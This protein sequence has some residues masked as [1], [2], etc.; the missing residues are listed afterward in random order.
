MP[1]SAINADFI[2]YDNTEKTRRSIERAITDEMDKFSLNH[3]PE[4]DFR[5]EDNTPDSMQRNKFFEDSPDAKDLD[6]HFRDFSMAGPGDGA[7]EL[8][9]S[10]ER[11]RGVP[12]ELGTPGIK[13]SDFGVRG[14]F[15]AS[16]SKP[17]YVSDRH[18]NMQSPSNA[19]SR[20]DFGGLATNIKRSWSPIENTRDLSFEWDKKKQSASSEIKRTTSAGTNEGYTGRSRLMDALEKVVGEES[21]DQ[22]RPRSAMDSR[23]A[24]AK[25]PVPGQYR[26]STYDDAATPRAK[27]ASRYTSVKQTSSPVPKGFK[28]QTSFMQ[29]IGLDQKSRAEKSFHPTQQYTA[30]FRIPDMTNI[31][32][33]MSEGPKPSP[34]AR[35]DGAKHV[36]INSVPVSDDDEKILTAL[37]TLQDKI[38]W[39]ENQNAN[40]GQRVVSL[41]EELR[42][43]RGLYYAEQKRA[44]AAEE[45]SRLRLQRTDSGVHSDTDHAEILARERD[46][47]RRVESNVRG[48]E[49]KIASL[50]RQLD[51]DRVLAKNLEE[52][53]D[54]AVRALAGA[55]DDAEKLKV[56]NERL[57]AE[58]DKLRRSVKESQERSAKDRIH[59]R[60][61]RERKVKPQARQVQIE[62]VEDDDD[63]ESFVDEGVERSGQNS[64]SFV[65]AVEVESIRKEME[66]ERRKKAPAFQRRSVSAPVP[67]KITVSKAVGT[68]PVKK[69]RSVSVQVQKAPK[70]TKK[71]V[72][73]DGKRVR[74]VIRQIVVEE[75]DSEMEETEETEE[76][77][78][79]EIEYVSEEEVEVL[80]RST[81]IGE[82][83]KAMGKAQT[84]KKVEK[85]NV[86]SNVQKIIEGLAHHNSASCSVCTRKRNKER[87]AQAAKE[88]AAKTAPASSAQNGVDDSQATI[89]PS[90]HPH[91]AL[92]S[93]LSQLEDEFRHLKLH[94][95][96]LLQEY[97]VMDPAVGKRRRKA[98]ASRLRDIIEELEAKADQIYALYD[99]LEAA[100]EEGSVIDEPAPK[101]RSANMRAWMEA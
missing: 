20:S 14:P 74:K 10:I 24:G 27:D 50:E 8:S 73:K 91:T 51:A 79:S 9:F 6:R 37:R 60:V 53:R 36:N 11:G 52:E 40:A 63:V 95:Q 67:K 31:S 2:D 42:H 7:S 86:N 44:Q 61:E 99:V 3:S 77:E 4:R 55:L 62:V 90:M 28:N 76:E 1:S 97:E 68:E 38:N 98:V 34:G 72:V 58:V 12:K 81:W 30:S 88:A 89:R 66:S 22:A 35:R 21:L 94:Y 39:L 70:S 32:A 41:E 65:D 46:E 13:S 23:F 18:L 49:A 33:L 84:Q 82:K 56:E 47:R 75:T 59:E 16:S 100:K 57:R 92:T 71:V 80:P 25:S 64:S 15:S 93:V 83:P 17:P 29:E 69:V 43:V 96:E 48:L 87:Q 54:E 45:E 26:K 101:G 85:P 5:G 78:E 19:S